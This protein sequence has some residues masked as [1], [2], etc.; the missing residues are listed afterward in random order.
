MSNASSD[1]PSSSN[2]ELPN[3]KLRQQAV[4]E[5]AVMDNSSNDVTAATKVNN[6][7]ADAA[8]RNVWAAKRKLEREKANLH[9]SRLQVTIF[10]VLHSMVTGNEMHWRLAFPLLA[11]ED[12]QMLYYCWHPGHSFP[13]MPSW[14]HYIWN[15]LILRPESY[16]QFL[17]IF[18]VA[19]G[20][21][22][23][24]VGTVIFC[25]ISFSSGKFKYIF[26]LNVL[27]AGTLLAVGILN[28]PIAEVFITV[29]H[30]ENGAISLYPAVTC[31]SSIAHLIPFILAV[32]GLLLFVPYALSLSYIYVDG[33]P[34]SPKNVMT[35]SNGRTDMLYLAIKLTVV[36]VWEFASSSSTKLAV[37]VP[38]LLIL[39]KEI[40]HKQPFHN[41]ILQMIRSGML[42]AATLSATVALISEIAAPSDSILPFALLCAA[43]IAGFAGGAVL[44]NLV[45]RWITVRV[46]DRFQKRVRTMH[47]A[48]VGVVSFAALPQ[49]GLKGRAFE[50]RNDPTAVLGTLSE[51]IRK[52]TSERSHV[53]PP[54]FESPHE[55]E[56]AC[57]FVRYSKN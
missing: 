25:A 7:R 20:I 37:L 16:E 44:N 51:D 12:M 13:G 54:M 29:L 55:V 50:M 27:R 15:P 6:D 2:L 46:Y 49:L 47:K 30:C 41:E 9:R 19:M 36:F 52:L 4:L 24:L 53:D 33:N 22:T 3:S 26:P 17:I 38:C 34:K 39:T 40:V 14:I 23:V 32:I 21:V 31:Y 11:F 56:L 10:Q 42:M 35:R 8:S 45:L 57:R 18:G 1:E 28:I 5:S 48:D 43:L